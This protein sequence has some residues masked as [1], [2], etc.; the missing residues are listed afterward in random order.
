MTVFALYYFT[1]TMVRKKTLKALHLFF[2]HFR[3]V[4]N[5]SAAAYT[6]V[7]D[8]TREVDQHCTSAPV[9]RASS[10][11]CQATVHSVGASTIPELQTIE[12]YNKQKEKKL[13]QLSPCRA[14]KD[15]L[16]IPFQ[17][18]CQEGKCQKFS[19]QNH[20]GKRLVKQEICCLL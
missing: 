18:A 16:T 17:N 8:C 2:T 15:A 19:D 11:L 7:Q 9:E 12:K 10:P 13:N 3:E 5:I 4:H 20:I 6:S 14:I 1:M